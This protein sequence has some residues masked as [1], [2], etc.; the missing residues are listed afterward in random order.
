MDKYTTDMK[1]QMYSKAMR[2]F[3]IEATLYKTSFSLNVVIHSFSHSILHSLL[4]VFIISD[5]GANVIQVQIVF[6]LHFV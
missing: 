2:F 4:T 6:V 1:I 3:F 5:H